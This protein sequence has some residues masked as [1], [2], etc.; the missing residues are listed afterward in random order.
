MIFDIGW[1]VTILAIGLRPKGQGQNLARKR[2]TLAAFQTEELRKRTLRP[3]RVRNLAYL[4]LHE[5]DQIFM[6][7]AEYVRCAA[8]SI[9]VA[10]LY[11]CYQQGAWSCLV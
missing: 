7:N 3:Q 4:A 10:C 5:N 6:L 1:E 9:R 8:W 2:G 11:S